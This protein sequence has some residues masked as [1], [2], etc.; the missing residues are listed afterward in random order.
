MKKLIVLATLVIT[1]NL[2]AQT[3]LIMDCIK[4]MTI[5]CVGSTTVTDGATT[6]N[7]LGGLDLI[8]AHCSGW[9]TDVC[10]WFYTNCDTTNQTTIAV[11]TWTCDQFVK[12]GQGE[13]GGG[14][15]GP[16]GSFP[17]NVPASCCSVGGW[18]IQNGQCC[19]LSW[20]GLDPNMCLHYPLCTFGGTNVI[21]GASST[22][23]PGGSP[24]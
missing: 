2:Q 24:Q 15:C 5:Y 22:N 10:L 13:G 4:S 11:V 3:P 9:D 23:N 18:I 12:C 14:S 7:V 8:S 19:G 20:C 16:D 6:T 21:N 17:I 1:I